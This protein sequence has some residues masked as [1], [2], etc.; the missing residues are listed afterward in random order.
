[1]DDIVKL[2]E[3]LIPN[4]KPEQALLLFML[5]FTRWL[6]MSIMMP[7]LGALVL[8]SLVR[9]AVASLLSTVS[10]FILWDQAPTFAQL[11]LSVI[12]FL[13]VKEALIGFILGFLASL[14]FYVYELFGELIDFARAASMSKLLVPE[15]RYPSSAM[16]TLLF[17]LALVIFVSLGLHRHF[18]SCAFDSF[19]SFPIM[20]TNL[21]FLQQEN[22]FLAITTI[23]AALFE[24]ALK[25]AFPVLLICFLID[26][27]FGLINR[28]APQI[29][30]YFLSIPVKAL[31]GLIILF[32]LL[33]YLISDFADH[34]WSMWR[35]F[36][37]WQKTTPS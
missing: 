9:L 31:G 28:V 5:I 1:M 25:L 23:L 21:D 8:P 15:L 17:Q 2:V 16:G 7:S 12:V 37:L 10:F 36:I 35:F 34:Y 3:A 30:A 4:T 33:P 14:I 6:M 18:I 11:T 20:A 13:F 27:A 29:N 22:L 19:Q 26:L 24:L 32:F